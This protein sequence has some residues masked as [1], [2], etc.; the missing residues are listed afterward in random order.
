MRLLKLEI[1]NLASLDNPEGEV[2]NFEEGALKDSTIFSIVGS[3]GSGKSTILDAICLALYNRAPRYPRQ[4]G[5]R[6]QHIEI[7]GEADEKEKNRLAPSDSRNILTRGKDKGHSKLTFLANDGNVYRA[8]WHVKFLRKKYDDAKTVLYRIDSKDGKTTEVE[9][10]WERLP[11]IIGLDYEQFLRTVLIAQGSFSKFLVASE[12][13]RYA[14]LEKLIGNGEMYNRISER[15]KEQKDNALKAYNEVNANSAAVKSN[16]IE[17]EAELE[18]LV[19]RIAELESE[20]MKDKAELDSIKQSLTWYA[21]EEKYVQNIGSYEQNL[22]SAVSRQNEQKENAARLALHDSTLPAVQMYKDIENTKDDIKKAE[23]DLETL[24]KQIDEKNGKQA[25]ETKALETLK[26]N[27]AKANKELEKQKPHINNARKIKG[28]LSAVEQVERDRT[29]AE[30]TARKAHEDAEKAVKD[31][32]AAIEEASQAHKTAQEKLAEVKNEIEGKTSELNASVINATKAYEEEN[33]K[34]AG[35]DPN[36]LQAA[37]SEAEKDSN[38]LKNGIRIS[39]DLKTK[40][41]KVDADSM[42]S[43]RLQTRNAEIAQ[44]LSKFQIESLAAELATLQDARTLMKSEAWEEHRSKLNDGDAC[45]LCGSTHHPYKN[46]EEVTRVVSELDGL[47]KAKEDEL[48]S[49]RD[50]KNALEVEKGKNDGT[51]KTLV[52]NIARLQGEIKVLSQEW[53]ALKRDHQAW[54]PDSEMLEGLQADLEA[55]CKKA[56]ADLTEYNELR[57]RIESLRKT[58]EDAEKTLSKY[59]N[60]ADVALKLA[61][62]AVTEANT[63]LQTAMGQKDNLIQQEGNR[64]AELDQRVAELESAKNEVIGKKEALKNEIGDKDP[65]SYEKELTD[66]KTAADGLVN[67]KNEDIRKIDEFIAELKGKL[68][69]TETA[70][71]TA[72][73]KM[74]ELVKQI[75]DWIAEFNSQGNALTIE[76]IAALSRATDNWDAIRR[77]LKD[78]GDAVTSAKTTLSN[79]KTKHEEHQQNKPEVDKET[80]ELRKTELE[81]KTNEELVEKKAQLQRHETAKKEMGDLLGKIQ[82]AER[83]KIEWEQIF[84]SI[85]SDGKILRKIAQCYTLRFLIEH[86]NVEIR[87]FNNRYELQQVKNSLGIRV[88]DHDRADDIRDTTSLSGGETFIVSLGLALGLSALSSNKISFEN[89]FIDEGFGTLDPET[90]TTVI[91]SLAMLQSSQG[92]KVGVISHTDTMSER[93]T[94]QI[95]IIKKGNS[96]SSR[97]EIYP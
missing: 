47:V 79:E 30:S 9:D 7:Y 52:D 51:L 96:G 77:L 45:P 95:R 38:D 23:G 90:L 12:D 2:I 58:K 69:A 83:E 17:D 33:A 82:E 76:E 14:L 71:E 94:T 87:K 48:Q 10:T 89:L 41:E 3:T 57:N 64:K 20:E 31:N 93:I 80:L 49:Q 67:L 29:T 88:I 50:S 63:R 42:E 13:E 54:E 92:K 22:N 16:I 27:A 37:K 21:D 39:K 1:L 25:E 91:D 75:K 55:A 85:G 46:G 15:I 53:D 59:K 78:L 44:A 40:Q 68:K 19:A 84:Q 70:K 74:D 61:G 72:A 81:G 73:N 26:E 86:A 8:E 56:D 43:K 18:A 65:D 6:K 24:K 36:A 35:M 60:E 4:K 62:D 11:D 32:A 28:E 5:D 97:I 34:T 66:K